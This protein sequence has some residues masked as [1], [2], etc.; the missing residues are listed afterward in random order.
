MEE[1]LIKAASQSD[2]D[3]FYKLFCRYRP[4]I[5]SIKNQFDIRNYDQDDW[6]QDAMIIC[7]NT[8]QNYNA[9]KGSFGNIYKF[10][11]QHHV[12]TLVEA[13]SINNIQEQ[14]MLSNTVVVHSEKIVDLLFGEEFLKSLSD[15]E[16]AA[17]QTWTGKYSL[18]EAAK[19]YEIEASVINRARQR[20][21]K[22]IMLALH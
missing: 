14:R 8:I 13:L 15:A 4:L 17:L 22:K 1:E 12:V 10:N 2:E 19:K 16:L 3:A 18:T 6:E 9:E 5:N 21:H 20:V 11:L 7:H